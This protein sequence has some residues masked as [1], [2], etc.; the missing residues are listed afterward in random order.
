MKDFLTAIGL[1]LVLEGLVLAAS[2]FRL[3][4]ILKMLEEMP[5]ARLRI[6]GLAAMFTGVLLVGLVKSFL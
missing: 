1:V 4:D 6:I 5:P 3:R 2:P